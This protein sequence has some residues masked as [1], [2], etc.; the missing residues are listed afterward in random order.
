[1]SVSDAWQQ[2]PQRGAAP[3][4][5]AAMEPTSGQGPN[6]TKPDGGSA[7]AII[8]GR[9]VTREWLSTELIASHGL[10][11]LLQRISLEAVRQEAQRENVSVSPADIEAEYS[12]TLKLADSGQSETGAKRK[13]GENKTSEGGSL[14]KDAV[15]RKQLIEQ[16]RLS[17]GVS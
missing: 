4:H 5:Q 9:P 15:L 7:V 1:Q 12:L 2:G 14:E 13:P 8:N 3:G 10:G 6:G 17:R 16:W 11:L